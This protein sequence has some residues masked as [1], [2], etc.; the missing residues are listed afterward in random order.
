MTATI[1]V[2]CISD[3]S[4]VF[5]F[6]PYKRAK[7]W[8]VCSLVFSILYPYLILICIR[9][10]K[11]GYLRYCYPFKFYPTQLNNTHIRSESKE[12]IWKYKNKYGISNIYL[13]LVV[14]QLYIRRPWQVFSSVPGQ[15]MSEL[16]IFFRP[17]LDTLGL[18]CFGGIGEG[19]N[20]Q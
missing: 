2:L 3:Y 9:I 11:V 5:E 15:V 12:K 10:P 19:V 4:S 17:S 18:E 20:P 16:D 7:I 1:E 13:Y 14:L 8:S 6:D